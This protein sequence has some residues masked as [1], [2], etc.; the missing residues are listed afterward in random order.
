MNEFTHDELNLLCIYSGGS[1]CE[2]IERLREMKQYLEADEQVLRD[3]TDSV[4][5]KLD[6]MTD[7]EYGKLDL[8]PDFDD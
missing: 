2:A 1:R 3:M 6:T 8:I 7:E 5:H 4:L